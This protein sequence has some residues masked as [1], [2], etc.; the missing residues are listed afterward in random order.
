MNI[1]DRLR[2]IA[3]HLR[4][5]TA[6]EAERAAAVGYRCDSY[7]EALQ[8]RSKRQQAVSLLRQRLRRLAG[9]NPSLRRAAGLVLLLAGLGLAGCCPVGES[10]RQRAGAMIA[11]AIEYNQALGDPRHE[12]GNA[13]RDLA[14][15]RAALEAAGRQ[16]GFGNP[17]QEG[18]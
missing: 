17:K 16:L 6:I 10:R 14:A 15:Q 8:G 9:N 1:T 12:P 11:T 5:L 13:P 3:G 4:T 18:K 2:A 7:D